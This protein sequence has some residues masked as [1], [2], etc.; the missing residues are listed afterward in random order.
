VLIGTL[1]W[2]VSPAKVFE[3][4]RSAEPSWL[5]A[6]LGCSLLGHAVQAWRLRLLAGG[7]GLP[8]RWRDVMEIHLASLAYTLVV[9]GGN[10]AGAAVRIVKLSRGLPPGTIANSGVALLVDRVVATMTL[11][12][13][14]LLC[15]AVARPADSWPWVVA[16][17]GL[18]LL[19]AAMLMPAVVGVGRLTVWSKATHWPV[20]DRL[21]GKLAKVRP[22]PIP[23]ITGSLTMAVVIHGF[24]VAVFVLIARS[25][26]LPLDWAQVGWARVVMLVAALLPISVAGLGLREGA[27]VLVLGGMQQDEGVALAMS[28]L[29]FAVVWVVPGMIG[30]VLEAR[31]WLSL[32]PPPTSEQATG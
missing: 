23:A 21:I 8:W 2:A 22:M 5:L 19:C 13:T 10:V 1:L 14:G 18:T 28:L 17:V 25:L 11:G 26:G 30:A 7:V 12:L 31:S 29:I 6:A 3:A 24:G 16:V 20:V 27:A 9:P 15:W 4:A 32:T